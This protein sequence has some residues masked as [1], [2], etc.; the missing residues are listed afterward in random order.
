M[1]SMEILHFD[2]KVKKIFNWEI[3]FLIYVKTQLS[4]VINQQGSSKLFT[5]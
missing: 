2:L 4:I 5:L 1:G 3:I